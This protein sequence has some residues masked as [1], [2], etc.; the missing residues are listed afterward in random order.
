MTVCQ[1]EIA[2]K[3]FEVEGIDQSGEIVIDKTVNTLRNGFI[4]GAL[5]AKRENDFIV[6]EGY[7]PRSRGNHCNL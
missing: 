1:G 2:L 4:Y 7:G 6:D 5:A 3:S